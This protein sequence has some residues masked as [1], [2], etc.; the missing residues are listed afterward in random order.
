V[1]SRTC[2]WVSPPRPIYK[3]LELYHL[4]TV[5][6]PSLSRG[7]AG[8]EQ[9]PTSPSPTA[10]ED[11]SGLLIAAEL[12][13]YN[14]DVVTASW[15]APYTGHR[16]TPGHPAPAQCDSKSEEGGHPSPTH[17]NLQEVYSSLCFAF[18][19]ANNVCFYF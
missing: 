8:H 15:Q 9:A 14:N 19:C 18:P 7:L 17:L 4:F 10:W 6:T 3:D 11:C 2:S 1:N 12:S 5:A 16:L 13:R